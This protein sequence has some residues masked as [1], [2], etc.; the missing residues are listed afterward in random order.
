[1]PGGNTVNYAA[2]AANSSGLT[3]SLDAASIAGG[4]SIN[5]ATGAVTYSSS[6]TNTSI[7]TVTAA[8][9]YGPLTSSHTVTINPSVATPVFTL[10]S[11]LTRCQGADIL[12]VNATAANSTGITYSMSP[13]GLNT[14]NST[15]GVVTFSAAWSGTSTITATAVGCNGPRTANHIITTTSTVGTPVFDLG[16]NSSRCQ[17]AITVTYNATAT[18]STGITYSLDAASLAEAIL[19]NA[20]TGEVSYIASWTGTS[21]ITATA[22]GCNGPALPRIR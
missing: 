18:N 8:G 22:A 11:T 19:I 4:N 17:E 3:Y 5:S 6:W 15:T 13:V 20:A 9:C 2:S 12:T 7:I 16:S 14:I 10:G 21:D 1:M